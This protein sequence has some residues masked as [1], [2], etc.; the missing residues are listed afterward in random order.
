MSHGAANEYT[1]NAAAADAARVRN[2]RV[3]RL[4]FGFMSHLLPERFVTS[5]RDH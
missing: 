5:L 1:V 3:R 4:V 2:T